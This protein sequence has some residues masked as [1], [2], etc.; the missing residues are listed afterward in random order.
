M[1][2]LTKKMYKACVSGDTATEKV[3]WLKAIRKSLKK[4]KTHVIKQVIDMKWI[5]L[6]SVVNIHDATDIP[7][8]INIAFPTEQACVQAAT[9]M[10]Y[11][12]KFDWFKVTAECKKES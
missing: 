9:S 11:I 7:G 4:K 1:K 10:T 8:K 3:L 6:L 2:K 5:L 12:V